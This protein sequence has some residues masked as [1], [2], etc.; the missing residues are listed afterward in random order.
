[1]TSRF[2]PLAYAEISAKSPCG[3]NVRTA[4]VNEDY[5]DQSEDCFAI[6]HSRKN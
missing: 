6:Y 4:R 1:M 5:W 2:A 3:V